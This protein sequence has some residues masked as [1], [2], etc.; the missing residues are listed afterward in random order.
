[1]NI[2]IHIYKKNIYTYIHI[3]RIYI[4]MYKVN[5]KTYI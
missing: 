1:M 3:R 2:D 4:H 5:K